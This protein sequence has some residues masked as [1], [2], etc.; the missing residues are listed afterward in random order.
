MFLRWM[1]KDSTS[2]AVDRFADE[3]LLTQR[4]YVPRNFVLPNVLK[5]QELQNLKVPALCLVGENER[6]YSAEKAVR[7]LKKVSSQIQT[8]VIPQAGHD[9]IVVQAEMVSRMVLRFLGQ[10]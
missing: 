1:F 8:E 10:H 2:E 9:L 5:D 6:L 7:R 4:C 3:T